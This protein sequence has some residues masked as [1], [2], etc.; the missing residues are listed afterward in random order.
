MFINK[1]Q[2]TDQEI[3]EKEVLFQD[4]MLDAEKSE[5]VFKELKDFFSSIPV[6]EA[7]EKYGMT[8]WR[9]YVLL[10]WDRLN[11]FTEEELVKIFGTQIPMALSLGFDVF[12]S[13]MSYFVANNYFEGNTDSLFIKIKESFQSSLV[14]V[15]TWQNQNIRMTELIKEIRVISKQNDSLRQA[16]FENKLRSILFSSNPLAEKY[17][18]ADSDKAVQNFID[19]VVFF[20]LVNSENITFIVH[21]FLNSI[22]GQINLDQALSSKAVTE[23]DQTVNSKILNETFSQSSDLLNNPKFLN[24]LTPQQ[25]KSQIEQEFKKDS[26]G[27]FENIELVFRKLE[28]FTEMYNDPKIADLLYFDEESGEFKWRV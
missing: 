11:T 19:I 5:K 18:F 15:G 27:N 13:L 26:E 16:E 22:G 8:Y 14:V 9:W 4:F 6:D 25:I 21:N 1:L 7:I 28:E 3:E 17:L 24:K 23:K 12:K 20:D 2:L 10:T